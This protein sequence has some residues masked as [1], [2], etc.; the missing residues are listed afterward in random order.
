ME[1]SKED[2]MEAKKQI[3]GVGEKAIRR[4]GDGSLVSE[5]GG[6]FGVLKTQNRAGDFSCP[7]PL[8]YNFHASNQR[9]V[10]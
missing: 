3:W 2:L 5:T 7:I 6:R 10:P 8:Y 1:Y 9:T 4:Q